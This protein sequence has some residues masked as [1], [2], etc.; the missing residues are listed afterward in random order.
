MKRR[1][2]LAG[3][4]TAAVI[5][6]G[7]QREARAVS[8]PPG[9][10]VVIVETAPPNATVYVDGLRTA[11]APPLRLE[12]APGKHSVQAF[13]E[14]S[15]SRYVE[16]EVAA[17][18]EQTIRLARVLG[19]CDVDPTAPGCGVDAEGGDIC[20]IDPSAPA[21]SPAGIYRAEEA[22][23]PISTSY[24]DAYLPRLGTAPAKAMGVAALASAAT[25]TIFSL[26][27]LHDRDDSGNPLTPRAEE[28]QTFTAI[29][30]AACVAAAAFVVMGVVLYLQRDDAVLTF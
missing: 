10:G 26:L 12:L 7:H 29:G 13:T 8:P 19:I 22:K 30:G 1:A 16:V 2:S 4:L 14:N 18:S 20:Q 23:R 28:H 15:D 25:G 21:C 11:G 24:F 9:R 17:G 5:V 3:L 6:I 27:A